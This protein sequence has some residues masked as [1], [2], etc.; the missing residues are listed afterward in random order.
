MAADIG[1][2]IPVIMPVIG[3]YGRAISISIAITLIAR[4]STITT[5]AMIRGCGTAHPNQ[6]GGNHRKDDQ[7]LAHC[8]P[9]KIV[10]TLR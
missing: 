8:N 1:T 9:P 10:H 4:V 5:V 2:A 7:N 6:Y 3:I